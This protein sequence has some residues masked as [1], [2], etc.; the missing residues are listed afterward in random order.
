MPSAAGA[1]RAARAAL[2]R[3]GVRAGRAQV[4]VSAAPD[5]EALQLAW[6]CPRTYPPA[7]TLTFAL[8]GF[9]GPDVVGAGAGAGVC[10]VSGERKCVLAATGAHADRCGGARS[11][12]ARPR[13][14]AASPLTQRAR[15]RGGG[16]AAGAG[17]AEADRAARA[18]CGRGRRTRDPR[19]SPPHPAPHLHPSRARKQG[20]AVRDAACPIST[21]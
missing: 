10:R 15:Q 20:S 16:V 3:G 2:A 19:R 1:R 11:P 8:A 9:S 7:E 13:L 17:G 4:D 6:R 18:A 14:P 21:G 12:P 5:K